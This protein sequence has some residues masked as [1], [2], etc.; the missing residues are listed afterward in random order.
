M[1]TLNKSKTKSKLTTLKNNTS[2]QTIL[3]YFLSLSLSVHYSSPQKI[4]KAY[5][6]SPNSSH[7]QPI[8]HFRKA[9]PRTCRSQYIASS[10]RGSNLQTTPFRFRT[11]KIHV[12][13]SYIVILTELSFAMLVI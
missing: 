13:C 4:P 7:D 2:P 12:R 11:T 9:F 5:I 10:T 8:I 3:T 1:I 6:Q